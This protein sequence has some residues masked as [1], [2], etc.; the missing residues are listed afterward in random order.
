MLPDHHL[1]AAAF[2]NPQTNA[3]PKR[4]N[5]PVDRAGRGRSYVTASEPQSVWINMTDMKHKTANR[6]ERAA[7]DKTSNLLL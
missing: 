5:T 4:V 7:I 1:A 6:L 2:A 3:N